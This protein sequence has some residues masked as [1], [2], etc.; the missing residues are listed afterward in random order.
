MLYIPHK[1]ELDIS[2]YGSK[3]VG[4]ELII[5]RSENPDAAPEDWEPVEPKSVPKWLREQR[6][7]KSMVNG[8]MVQKEYRDKHWYRA[9]K[10]P[11]PAE[12]H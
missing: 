2:K 3:R 1:P 4:V 10:I 6:I 11:A 8:N 5:L 12:A 9:E 7:I